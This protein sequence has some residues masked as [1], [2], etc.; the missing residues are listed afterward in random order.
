MGR[1]IESL[2]CV[3]YDTRSGFM[4]LDLSAL[5]PSTEAMYHQYDRNL[6]SKVV[7]CF[8]RGMT[9]GHITTIS[10]ELREIEDIIRAT[11]GIDI[12]LGI[13]DEPVTNAWVLIPTINGNHALLGPEQQTGNE[14]QIAKFFRGVAEK[15]ATS[16]VDNVNGKIS[17]QFTKITFTVRL[18]SGLIQSN[19]SAEEISAVLFHEIGHIWS[20]C[21]WFKNSIMRNHALVDAITKFVGAVDDVER[22]MV[23]RKVEK[24]HTVTIKNKEYLA[25]NNDVAGATVVILDA[26]NRSFDSATGSNIYD[27]RSWEALSDQ[28]VARLGGGMYLASSLD[29]MDRAY[30][31]ASKRSS[32]WFLVTE[33]I[34]FICGILFNL[35]MTAA[36]MGIWAFII[37]AA[38][39]STIT[40][41]V[42][43]SGLFYDSYDRPGERITR[44]RNELVDSL[45][46]RSIAPEIRKM[47]LSDIAFLD[48]I[49]AKTKDRFTF[50]TQIMLF[51]SS[52]RR[53]ELSEIQQQQALEKIANSNLYVLGSKLETLV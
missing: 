37:I 38:L 20:Y 24:E 35:V 16:E 28:Y 41:P 44:I 33:S 11:T 27:Y 51:L 42:G 36:T 52:N 31:D 45:K 8:K 12:D 23:L 13:I 43:N 18:T 32:L 15:Y 30:G 10:P 50:W 48:N 29:K 22:T 46:N 39:V 14:K 6:F 25:T 47:I 40:T 19:L 3:N 7:D 1:T 5:V 9:S 34:K 53:K 4:Q 2:W 26:V 49:L 17:G 21:A